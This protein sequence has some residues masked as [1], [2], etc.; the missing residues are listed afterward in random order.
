MKHFDKRK[1]KTV[2]R[3][4]SFTRCELA[5]I[6]YSSNLCFDYYRSLLHEVADWFDV[7]TLTVRY[8]SFFSHQYEQFLSGNEYSGE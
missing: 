6:Q 5:N 3:I 4:L 8:H 1:T 7:A 2:L